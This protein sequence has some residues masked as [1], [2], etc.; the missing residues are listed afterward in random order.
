MPI[1]SGAGNMSVLFYN[2]KKLGFVG[3]RTLVTDITDF[4][5]YKFR[6]NDA[7]LAI[8]HDTTYLYIV[9]NHTQSGS[10]SAVRDRQ[11][12]EEMTTLRAM[13]ASFPNLIDMGDFN[14]A[15]SFEAGY[16]AVT[17]SADSNTLLY[18]PP[19]YPDKALQYP[20]NWDVTPYLV[21]PYLTT[22][23]RQSAA[24]PNSCGTSGGAKSWY[25]HIFLSPWL[26][27]GSNYVRY[28]PHSYLTIGND[29]NRIGVDI[30]SPSPA[31]NTSVPAAVLQALF[32][33]SDKYPVAVKL[34][35]QA[36]RN[37]YSPADPGS[38]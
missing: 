2:Q 25:D 14:T 30:T 5:L 32:E 12:G 11:V 15:N 21:A 22:T 36:N 18:D 29:G 19:Y 9:V 26:I 8:T 4:N 6:Y 13:F 35:V 38:F 16:Q 34:Q 31:L 27:G 24:I 10:S 33:F 37:G 20:G 23:T 3:E 1:A 17:T 7:N 28:V